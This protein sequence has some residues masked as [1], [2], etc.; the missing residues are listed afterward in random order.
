MSDIGISFPAWMT[1]LLIGLLYWPLLVVAAA[2]LAG[3]AIFLRGWRRA[4]LLG[5]A[6]IATL[7]CL[8]VLGMDIVS[9]VHSAS[10]RRAYARAHGTLSA[11]LQIQSLDLPAGTAVTW[12]NER[13]EAVASVELPG[14]TRL[15]GTTLSGKLDDVSGR[16]WSGVLAADAQL[17]GWPC[18]AGDV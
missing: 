18:R 14:P 4:G 2:V 11:P 7:P 12:A 8:M 5:L 17:E 6:G 15:L 16:W 9:A 3:L 10:A 13:H 1:P